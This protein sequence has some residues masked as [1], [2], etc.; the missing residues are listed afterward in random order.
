MGDLDKH[1][2]RVYRERLL[3]S[4]LCQAHLVAGG[5]VG[6]RGKRWI[7]ENDGKTEEEGRTFLCIEDGHPDVRGAWKEPRQAVEAITLDINRERRSFDEV[8]FYYPTDKGSYDGVTWRMLKIDMSFLR[9]VL[10]HDDLTM[11]EIIRRF[12]RI[13]EK[14]RVEGG[15]EEDFKNLN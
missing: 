4:A 7:A 2:S 12:V 10:D 5:G 11:K 15:E 6:F 9:I 13:S 8:F 14:T 1:S 3:F